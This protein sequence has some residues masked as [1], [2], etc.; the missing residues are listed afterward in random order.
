MDR[1]LTDRSPLLGCLAACA[2]SIAGVATTAPSLVAQTM[3]VTPPAM[4]WPAGGDVEVRGAIA[5]EEC[6]IVFARAG[7]AQAVVLKA[8]GP[9][10]S[11]VLTV[12]PIAGHATMT[13]AGYVFPCDNILAGRWIERTFT[14]FD[15]E[16]TTDCRTLDPTARMELGIGERVRLRTQ[17]AVSVTWAVTPEGRGALSRRT[18]ASTVY[19]ASFSPEQVVV[20][21]TATDA[22]PCEL[23]FRTH[24]PGEVEFIFVRDAPPWPLG[25]RRMGFLTYVTMRLWPPMR[26]P[27]GISF[28]DA[29]IRINVP[30][31]RFQWP[32]QS[33]DYVRPAR[34][35]IQCDCEN[36]LTNQYDVTYGLQ[37][38]SKL[39]GWVGIYSI[40]FDAPFE[41]RNE[42]GEWI[43]FATPGYAFEYDASGP[44]RGRARG[45]V[46]GLRNLAWQGPF[47]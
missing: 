15:I 20:K 27:P 2:L 28:Q 41:Y 17:P 22:T 11:V 19:R 12:P 31:Q 40:D 25:E 46:P 5:E 24:A 1:T 33:W 36:L 47:R 18:G 45:S 39:A 37:P 35:A 3:F 14:L 23:T 44:P 16:C 6:I 26:T 13:F 10:Y 43:N 4:C 7:G 21:A 30:L 29:R 9:T 34:F 8:A 38:I 42:D 32:D